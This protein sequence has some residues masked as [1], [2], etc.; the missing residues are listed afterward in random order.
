MA[1]PLSITINVNGEAT[2][3]NYQ[4]TPSMSLF[5]IGVI[6]GSIDDKNKKENYKSEEKS[7]YGS[8]LFVPYSFPLVR[9]DI[10]KGGEFID[11]TKVND[12]DL[13]R[14]LTKQT[15]VIRMLDYAEARV[16][17]KPLDISAS[18]SS[19]TLENNVKLITQLIFKNGKNLKLQ[20]DIYTVYNNNMVSWK[21]VPKT[22]YTKEYVSAIINISVSR[23]L[24]I[25][26][27]KRQK[28][29]CP[30][31]RQNLRESIKTVFGV[32]LLGEPSR[33]LPMGIIPK[34]LLQPV[35]KSSLYSK[36]NTRRLRDR[37]RSAYPY[38]YRNRYPYN[39]PY[40]Y[41]YDSTRQTNRD[42]LNRLAQRRGGKGTKRIH[43]NT[44]H[45]N[46][47]THRNK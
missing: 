4:Y 6:S 26:F 7:N 12:K 43:R 36:Y 3:K 19:G 15:S 34:R 8:Q 27:I 25:G 42:Y 29:S 14:A 39:Y 23:G 44:T 47:K 2:A 24:K 17:Q 30:A 22:A 9:S 41:P 10:I 1:L 40:N 16:G 35:T 46:N 32:D 45:R 33:T 11:V 28:L 5:D 37:Y 13:I 31:N 38:N 20:G 21:L 18:I